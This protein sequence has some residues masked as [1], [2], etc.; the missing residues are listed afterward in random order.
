MPALATYA[1]TTLEAVKEELPTPGAGVALDDKLRRRVNAASR[2][3]MRYSGREFKSLVTNPATRVFDMV[4]DRVYLTPYDLQP[5][6]AGLALSTLTGAGGTLVTTALTTSD[7][8]FP[9][10][11]VVNTLTLTNSPL[12]PTRVSVTGTWGWPSVPEDVEQIVIE[13][14][15]DSIRRDQFLRTNLDDTGGVTPA[16]MGLFMT[17]AQKA[18]LDLM[19]VPVVA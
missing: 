14:V 16:R 17:S 6:G 1:L 9:D 8:L 12:L 11:A 15:V 7:Y 4:G 13:M 18:R 10:G 3:V 19:R 5:A 2:E